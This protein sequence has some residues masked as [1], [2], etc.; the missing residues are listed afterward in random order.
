M[1]SPLPTIEGVT[2]SRHWLPRGPW[3]TILEFL[4][5]RFP[6]I[7]TE[8]WL[9]RMESGEVL[10]ETGAR[11]NQDS[12]F[13]EGSCI[14]YYRQLGDERS[15]PFDES[16][17]YED[18][19]I[20]VVDKPHFLPVIPAGRF[21]RETLLVR[22]RRQGKPETLTPVHRLDRETA[23]VVLFA[24]NP[25]TVGAYTK[26][27]RDRKV[28]KTY[29]ALAPESSELNF[30]LTRK[31][32]IEKGEPFFRMREVEGE[33][34]AETHVQQTD[35]SFAASRLY[36]LQPIT[37]KKHQLRVHMAALGIPIVNDRLYPTYVRLANNDDD[38]AHP[39]QLIARSIGFVDPVTGK[40]LYFESAR[41]F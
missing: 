38:F 31:T 20:L 11:V 12:V 29:E 21:L 9:R 19:N 41:G 23:G 10:D 35:T 34:N 37:G 17:L 2:A 22:L 5:D 1:K 14:F 30:P 25:Q 39:L 4:V 8:T 24:L 26:L 40:E 6:R 33:P 3:K 7:S 18:E 15:I 32:R 36:R 27:F 16:I 28:Q 13:R